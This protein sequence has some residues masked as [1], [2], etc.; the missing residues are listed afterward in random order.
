M[1]SR[2]AALRVPCERVLAVRP[3]GRNLV[4]GE[5]LH[6]AYRAGRYRRWVLGSESCPDRPRDS[7]VPPSVAV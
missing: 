5:L 6:V 1:F 2:R 3:L 7:G 4:M